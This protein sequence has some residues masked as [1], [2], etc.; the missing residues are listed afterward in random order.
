MSIKYNKIHVVQ[1]LL[2]LRKSWT[3]QAALTRYLVIPREDCRYF[4]CFPQL[5]LNP[6]MTVNEFIAH[7]PQQANRAHSVHP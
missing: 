7:G 3:G 4:T 5:N 6:P 2:N 1:N